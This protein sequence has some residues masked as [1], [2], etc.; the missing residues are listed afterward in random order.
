[1]DRGQPPDS[2]E[3]HVY[4]IEPSETVSDA[5][6]RAVSAVT[7]DTPGPPDSVDEVKR[8]RLDPLYTTIDPDALNDL[9]RGKDAIG[10]LTFSY[11]GCRVRVYGDG[12]VAVELLDFT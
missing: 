10:A 1:M 7:G 4:E 9:F 3:P 6:I 11:A 2:A 8:S 12:R 5:V